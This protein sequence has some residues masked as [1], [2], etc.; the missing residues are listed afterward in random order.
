MDEH[1]STKDAWLQVCRFNLK[2]AKFLKKRLANFT[3]EKHE[4]FLLELE[5][6][7]RLN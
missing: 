7:D 2:V 6:L 3:L 4:I 5:R 1:H